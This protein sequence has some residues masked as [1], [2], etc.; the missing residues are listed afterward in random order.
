MLTFYSSTPILI[1][2]APFSP[3]LETRIIM[4]NFTNSS[5]TGDLV[6][7]FYK[8]PVVEF[9]ILFLKCFLISVGIVANFGVVLTALFHKCPRK[10]AAL[11]AASLCVSN[12]FYG[13]FILFFATPLRYSDSFKQTAVKWPVYCH[14]TQI[15]SNAPKTWIIAHHVW[16]AVDTFWLIKRPFQYSSLINKY[17]KSKFKDFHI[18][19]RVWNDFLLM[20]QTFFWYKLALLWRQFTKQN[21][22]SWTFELPSVSLVIVSINVRKM[23]QF[24]FWRKCSGL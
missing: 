6:E 3:T 20:A 2:H 10:H 21:E 4:T 1:L 18:F 22:I 23:L 7:P 9:S 15:G 24:H 14:A 11:A 12:I 19:R 8:H 13:F 5:F 16:I 17:F